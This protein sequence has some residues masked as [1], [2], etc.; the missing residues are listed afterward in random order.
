VENYVI[1][2]EK[3]FK[4][5]WYFAHLFVILHSK[6]KNRL[7]KAYEQEGISSRDTASVADCQP[8]GKSEATPFGE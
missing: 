2:E 6:D 7:I 3:M 8:T 5:I 1:Y 4:L